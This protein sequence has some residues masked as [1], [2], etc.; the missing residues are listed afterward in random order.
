V[1]FPSLNLVVPAPGNHVNYIMVL[2]NKIKKSSVTETILKPAG[3]VS[4]DYSLI[5]KMGLEGE[6]A[7][8]K[9]IQVRM[10][11]VLKSTV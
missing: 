11:F 10:C 1:L 7:Q 8:F 6:K 5:V 4:N 2:E 9:A 3:S